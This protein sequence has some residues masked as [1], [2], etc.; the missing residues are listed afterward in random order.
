MVKEREKYN[1]KLG[2]KLGRYGVP[3]AKRPYST[4]SNA[5]GRLRQA[6]TMAYGREKVTET[7][8]KSS[9]MRM[10]A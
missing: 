4:V 5:P 6:L 2:G 10:K 9:F 7:L 8:V 3:E 1:S